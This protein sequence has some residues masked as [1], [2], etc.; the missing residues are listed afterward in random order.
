MTTTHA[1]DSAKV[2]AEFAALYA[3]WDE[4]IV[5]SD[6]VTLNKL[7]ADEARMTSPDGKM[8]TKAESI[9]QIKSGQYKAS[10]PSTTDLQ[11]RLYGDTAVV[12]CVWK[13]AEIIQGKKVDGHYR[14]TDVWVKR[15]GRWQVV[16]SHG[17]PVE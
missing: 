12:T 16:A 8:E 13:A 4:A 7:Y 10:N 9:G 15:E 11:V 17:T 3:Q 1:A 5:K 14:F 2:S 6:L